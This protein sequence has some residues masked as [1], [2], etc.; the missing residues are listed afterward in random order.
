MKARTKA[1]EIVKALHNYLEN[2]DT[3]WNITDD[4]K[5]TAKISIGLISNGS[6]YWQ[7]VK[8]EIDKLPYY[9]EDV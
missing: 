3:Y 2:N 4:A 7:D 5:E 6:K 8:N 9:I 1:I